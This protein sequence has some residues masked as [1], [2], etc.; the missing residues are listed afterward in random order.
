[1]GNMERFKGDEMC[2]R[3]RRYSGSRRSQVELRQAKR[4]ELLVVDEHA[5]HL[6]KRLWGICLTVELAPHR[7]Q[8]RSRKKEPWSGRPWGTEKTEMRCLAENRTG[9]KTS[10]GFEAGSMGGQTLWQH[11]ERLVSE[12]R[13]SGGSDWEVK[14]W[15][16]CKGGADFDLAPRP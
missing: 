2:S 7:V 13:E 9:G 5:Q 14:R 4:R 10:F 1:M 16:G 12:R 15:Q 11:L 3:R 8:E 6:R